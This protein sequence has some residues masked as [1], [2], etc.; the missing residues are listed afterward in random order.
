MSK[1]AEEIAEKLDENVCLANY[2][3]R[4][5]WLG[6]MSKVGGII[7]ANLELVKEGVQAIHN[8]LNESLKWQDKE[9]LIRQV[10]LVVLATLSEEE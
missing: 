5:E 4:D 2:A 1:L 3:S 10:C 6:L 7:A 9:S 8:T